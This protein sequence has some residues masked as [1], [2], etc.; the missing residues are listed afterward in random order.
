ML[1][2]GRKAGRVT[3]LWGQL[4][5]IALAA[6]TFVVV[7]HLN[8]SGFVGAF[9]AG[10]AF[11]AVVPKAVSEEGT[12][13]ATCELLEMVVFAFFGA[14]AVWQALDDSPQIEVL[15]YAVLSLALFRLI[16]VAVATAGPG[17]SKATVL[18]MGWLVPAVSRRCSA[19][20]C[21]RRGS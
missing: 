12:A 4:Y 5:V 6:L 17:L 9:G 21:W 2:Y 19:F 20:W 8:G 7:E 14:A 13:E 15:L 11:A 10:L 16:G 18:Y 1:T 3:E